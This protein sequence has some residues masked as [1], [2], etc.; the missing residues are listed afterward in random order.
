MKSHGMMLITLHRWGC[1]QS[2]WLNWDYNY[3]A[4]LSKITVG[5]IYLF[6]KL[7]MKHIFIADCGQFLVNCFSQEGWEFVIEGSFKVLGNK[8]TVQVF[9]SRKEMRTSQGKGIFWQWPASEFKSLLLRWLSCK[10]RWSWEYPAPYPRV[11]SLI[12]ILCSPYSL[13]SFPYLN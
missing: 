2:G 9:P 6:N 4:R 10:A 11:N 8:P 7:S 1:G 13:L 12:L 5:A 3:S